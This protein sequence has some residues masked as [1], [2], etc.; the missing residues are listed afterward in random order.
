LHDR[1]YTKNIE[2]EMMSKVIKWFWES[3]LFSMSLLGISILIAFLFGLFTWAVDVVADDVIIL[4]EVPGT[5]T[6]TIIRG[7]VDDEPVQ[8]T[9]TEEQTF[10]TV[11]DQVISIEHVPERSFQV[12][13]PISRPEES[14]GDPFEEGGR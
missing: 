3:V 10:G 6:S 14:I 2:K 13:I 11:G 12:R 8:L 4:S 9:R 5:G 1:V 7:V